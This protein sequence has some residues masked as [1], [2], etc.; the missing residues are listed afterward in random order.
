MSPQNCL[1]SNLNKLISL[2]L[3]SQ[4]RWSIPLSI[5]V[6]LL[7]GST[8]TH[9]SCTRGSW[10]RHSFPDWTSWRQS[11]KGQSPPSSC[12]SPLFWCNPGYCW[13]S[14]LQKHSSGS[15]P[16]FHPPE[17]PQVFLYRAALS[18]FFSQSV[19]ITEIALTQVQHPALDLVKPQWIHIAPLFESVQVPLDVKSSSFSW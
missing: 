10:P 16:A 14:W 4:Q 17:T 15:C 8:P 6:A 9:L 13:L 12:W 5:F 1:F 11:R 18:E 19:Q 3:S 7:C 2:S